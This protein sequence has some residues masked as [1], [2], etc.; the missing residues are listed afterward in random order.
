MS[1]FYTFRYPLSLSPDDRRGIQHLYGRPRLA[2]TSHAPALGSQAG[3]DTNEIAL[4]EVRMR[5]VGRKGRGKTPSSVPF[6]ALL[7]LRLQAVLLLSHPSQ[8]PRQMS[9]RLPLTQ[10]PPSEES[11][12]SSRQALC[13]ACAVGACSLGILLWPHGTGKDC[14]ARWMQLSRMPRARSGSS[15]VCGNWRSAKSSDRGLRNTVP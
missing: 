12:S 7:V 8:K 5:C 1:P 3:M 10:F 9:V 2:P 4:L 11:S 13:G 14:P 6:P 15:K